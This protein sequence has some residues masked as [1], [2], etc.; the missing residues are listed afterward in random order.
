M[1]RGPPRAGHFFIKFAYGRVA[2]AS[3]FRTKSFKVIKSV[4]YYRFSESSQA[5]EQHLLAGPQGIS[6]TAVRKSI[7]L[8]NL[9]FLKLYLGKTSFLTTFSHRIRVPCRKYHLM[10]FFQKK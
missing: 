7:F 8:R 4:P 2:V 10:K 1:G 5:Q 6:R 3:R 9:A